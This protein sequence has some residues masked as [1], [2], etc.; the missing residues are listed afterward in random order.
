MFTIRYSTM[1]LFLIRHA[2]AE[3]RSLTGRDRDRRLTDKGKKTMRSVAEALRTELE[4][5][6]LA[7]ASTLVRARETAEIVLEEA[8]KKIPLEFSSALTPDADIEQDTF[9]MLAEIFSR[10]GVDT[11]AV[12]GHEPHL[13]YLASRILT[14]AGRV[15]IDMK[16]SSVCA[17]ELDHVRANDVRGYLRWHVVPKLFT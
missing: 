14:G 2:E 15:M 4:S 12:I 17:I 7:I 9:P 13:G 1:R 10:E 16:K 5:I 11:V 8:G 6:D 3:D